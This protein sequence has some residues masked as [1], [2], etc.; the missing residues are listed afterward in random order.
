LDNKTEKFL[1]II[2]RHKGLLFKVV[3]A[4]C[5]NRALHKDLVQ[6]II[7]QLWSSFDNYD[8]QFKY[9]T[10]IYRIALN[11]AISFYRKGL[12]ERNYSSEFLP[13]YENIITSKE[14]YEEDPNLKLL[15]QFILEL[16]EIDKALI[17][18]YLEGLSHKEIAPIIGIS[19]TNVGTK[20]SRIKNI[21]RKKFKPLT[22]INTNGR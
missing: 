5:E 11:T 3:N 1:A 19:P 15:N 8:D 14:A 21:L 6:E 9:S 12:R 7:L 22:K 10:W 16:K 4:Y 17:L 2:D 18:L 20:L 13:Q